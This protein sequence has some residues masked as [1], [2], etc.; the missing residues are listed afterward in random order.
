M[1]YIWH[2]QYMKEKGA[3]QMEQKKVSVFSVLGG[4][5]KT[6]VFLILLTLVGNGLT[7]FV[8]KFIAKN[9]DAYTAGVFDM[10]AAVWEFIFVSIGVFVFTYIQS[11][12]QTYASE[13]VAKDLRRKVVQKISEQ[14]YAY[15]Q[16]KDP[17]K[18]LT[19]LTSDIDSVK[20]FV[21]QAIVSIVSSFAVIVGAAILLISI[22]W[23]LGLVVL[24][25]IPVIGTVFFFIFSKIRVLFL[26]TREIVDKLNKVINESILGAALIRVVHGEH[27]EYKK[28]LAV[29]TEAKNTG[30]SILKLFASLIP[31]ITFVSGL[32]TIAIVALGGHFVIIG[33]MSL[34]QFTAFYTYLAM[35]IFPILIIGFMSN[36]IAQAS[37]SYTRIASVLDSAEPLQADGIVAPIVG[38]IEVQDVSLILRDTTILQHISFSVK[39]NTRTAIIGPTAA[40]KTQLLYMLSGLI[41]PTSGNILYGNTPIDAYDMQ[42]FHSQVGLVFQDSVIFNTTIR[43]NIAFNTSVT[44]EALLRAIQ[45]A[46]LE[47]FIDALPEKLY[48]VIS[49]RGSNLSGGQ[50]QRIMLARALA[51]NPSVLLLDDF[52]A[53]VDIETERTILQNIKHNYPDLT[54]ISVTQK[55]APVEDYDAIILL[56][57]GELIAT[58]THE[59]LLAVVP[60]YAQLYNTQQSTQQYEL[61]T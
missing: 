3:P 1:L 27:A 43:E 57:E 52:T 35:L 28:F 9:I 45:T 55:I 6:I 4:Y 47:D 10:H 53:R 49:E 22:N 38:S 21:S 29:N 39:K 33:A 42:S 7:L 40:G 24:C 13:R 31:L 44:E 18:L 25:V 23:K 50:K 16:K 51:T 54:L 60:E 2:N 58:G 59:Q 5:K 14:N 12:V 41:Q 30:L 17:A 48:T 32:G 15:I 8:P 26:R 37:A 20:L 56:M 11:V 34:G 36:I 19:V 61:Q 46:A